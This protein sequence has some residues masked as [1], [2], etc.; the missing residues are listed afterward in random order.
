MIDVVIPTMCLGPKDW[1]KYTLNE[2]FICKEVKKII[3]IDNTKDS[4]YKKNFFVNDKI[5]LVE[6]KKNNFVNPSWNQGINLSS[7]ENYL[8]LNDDILVSNIVLSMVDKILKTDNNIG[9]LTVLTNEHIT[10]DQ[11]IEKSKLFDENRISFTEKM[12]NPQGIQGWFMA[13]RKYEWKNIPEEIKIWYGDNFIF[14]RIKSLNKKCLNLNSCMIAHHTSSTVNNHL[15][16]EEIFTIKKIIQN[17][18]SIVRKTP[19]ILQA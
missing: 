13:G 1:F 14:N 6:N 7:S 2:L 15:N 9:L 18:I 12:L 11:Y 4:L 16:D 8:I 10:I 19:R 5:I 17:D 3:I